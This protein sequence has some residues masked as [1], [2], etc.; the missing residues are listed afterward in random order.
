MWRIFVSC[1]ILNCSITYGMQ[2]QPPLLWFAL[3]RAINKQGYDDVY[4]TVKQS[5]YKHSFKSDSE[6]YPF[7]WSESIQESDQ[8][9]TAQG[10]WKMLDSVPENLG[11]IREVDT[12]NSFNREGRLYVIVFNSKKTYVLNLLEEIKKSHGSICES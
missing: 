3:Q 1:M 7:F 11:G 9:S 2:K 12:C 8:S 6:R 5:S 4:R 10:L